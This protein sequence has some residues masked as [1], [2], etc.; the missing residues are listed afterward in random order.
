MLALVVGDATS[1]K[2]QDSLPSWDD[3]TRQTSHLG[4]AKTGF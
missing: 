2:A 1:A 4:F 3:G